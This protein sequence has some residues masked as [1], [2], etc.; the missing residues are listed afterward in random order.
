MLGFICEI[1]TYGQI[2][3]HSWD[4]LL[5]ST[6]FMLQFWGEILR[7]NNTELKQT[8]KKYH[9]LGKSYFKVETN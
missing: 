3:N 8:N 2:S 5:F 9:K 7:E 4:L 6:N 1:F